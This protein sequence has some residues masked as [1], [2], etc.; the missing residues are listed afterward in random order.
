MISLNASVID[1]PVLF[2]NGIAQANLLNTSIT[3]QMYLYPLFHLK[4]LSIKTRSADQISSIL[5][6]ITFLVWNVLL[7]GL[8]NSSANC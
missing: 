3:V 1:R 8:C 7:I 5:L 2:F 4:S 6:A